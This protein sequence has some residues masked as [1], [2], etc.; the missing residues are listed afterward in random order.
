M[1]PWWRLYS[2][3]CPPVVTFIPSLHQGAA[4]LPGW[5][6]GQRSRWNLIQISFS[7]PGQVRAPDR[8]VGAELWTFSRVMS[9][10]ES[11]LIFNFLLRDCQVKTTMVC[12]FVFLAQPPKIKPWLVTSPLTLKLRHSLAF[13][14]TQCWLVVIK[15]QSFQDSRVRIQTWKTQDGWC[16]LMQRQLEKKCQ[17]KLHFSPLNKQWTSSHSQLNPWKDQR[18]PLCLAQ[19]ERPLS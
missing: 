4:W 15:T 12:L 19:T 8:T 2:F 17:L 13:S 10:F 16:S 18:W 11:I 5:L 6:A 3:T 7:A 1:W 14:W 9:T